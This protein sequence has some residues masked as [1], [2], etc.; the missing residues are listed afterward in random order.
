[1]CVLKATHT[2]D[3]SHIF[4]PK[5]I[6]D[7]LVMVCYVCHGLNLLSITLGQSFNPSHLRFYSIRPSKQIA[8]KDGVEGEPTRMRSCLPSSGC[9]W[10]ENKALPKRYKTTPPASN[11]LDMIAPFPQT[12]RSH[13]PDFVLT[14]VE[15]SHTPKPTG[16][17]QLHIKFSRTGLRVGQN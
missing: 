13:T 12:V 7:W 2:H 5:C 11:K 14:S 9:Y 4:L 3:E 1:M 8:H 6:Y 10:T 15:I 16:V 17:P